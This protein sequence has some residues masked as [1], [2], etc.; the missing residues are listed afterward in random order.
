MPPKTTGVGAFIG[1]PRTPSPSPWRPPPGAARALSKV[2]GPALR[3]PDLLRDVRQHLLPPEEQ[4]RQGGIQLLWLRLPPVPEFPP[5]DAQQAVPEYQ[6]QEREQ[7]CL[8]LDLCQEGTQG[9][10]LIRVGRITWHDED[11]D[12]L[13]GGILL[14]DR[15]GLKAGI[16][17]TVRRQAKRRK[18]GESGWGAA[19]N[20]PLL[21]RRCV[22]KWL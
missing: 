1:D 11:C 21:P 22:R 4:E 18:A 9:G 3:G 6:V 10:V 19:G 16:L 7:R 20:I 2:R 17:A 15:V 14:K 13:D 12:V 5:E 8:P